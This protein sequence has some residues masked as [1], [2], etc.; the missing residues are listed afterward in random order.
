MTFIEG[1]ICPEACAF[2]V[3]FGTRDGERRA[4]LTVDHVH[5]N[6]GT[7]VDVEVA[8]GALIVT[9][10]DVY[11]PGSRHAVGRRHGS[12][13]E[14]TTPVEGAEV[15]RLVTTAGEFA[16]TDGMGSTGYRG[17]TTAPPV[18]STSKEGYHK[19]ETAVTIHGDTRYDVELLAVRAGEVPYRS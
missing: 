12:D 10:T 2:E 16:T 13:V 9:E 14:G 11:P 3:R 6:P 1:K 4:Y 15:W 18:V 8:G 5:W 19:Q 17:S 7:L